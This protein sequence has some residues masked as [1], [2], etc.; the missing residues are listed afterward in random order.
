MAQEHIFFNKK[1]WLT[2]MAR[3]LR[4]KMVTMC[5]DEKITD[6][7]NHQETSKSGGF[8]K[9]LF[10]RGRKLNTPQPPATTHPS[11]RG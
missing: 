6:E 7:G 2:S 5:G 11:F 3:M 1:R 10:F 8:Q 9:L 4:S